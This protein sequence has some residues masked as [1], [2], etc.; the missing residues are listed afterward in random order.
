MATHANKRGF[1]L[2]IIITC[3]VC[4][5]PLIWLVWRAFSADLGV[6]PIETIVRQLGV[7]GLRFLVLGLLISPLAY[8]I[9]QP[10]LLRLRRPIGLFGFFYISLHLASYVGLDHYFDW[11]RIWADIVKR[12]FITFGMIGFM[13]LIPLVIT[14]FNAAIKAMGGMNWRRL[15]MLYYL[16]VPLGV[17]HY[18]LL[19]KADKTMPLIYGTI[20]A[21]LIGFRV[22]KRF[23]A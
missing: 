14:S 13:L 21:A 22:W 5:L 16:I 20:F 1:T 23:K 7:W 15:H 2:D 6:N 11:A 12:P 18:F 10:R 17:L 9:R 8:L 19:V 3:L 4:C